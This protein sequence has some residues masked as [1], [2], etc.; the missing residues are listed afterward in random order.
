M[1]RIG[2]AI[3]QVP[4][5]VKVSI[6]DQEVSLESSKGKQSY[7]MPQG[8][9]ASLEEMNLSF[10]RNSE[11][12]KL[13]ALHGTTRANIANIAKGLS[14]GWSKSLEIIGVGYRVEAKGK[15]LNFILGYSHPILLNPPEGIEFKLDGNTKITVLGTDKQ[16]VG[17]VAAEIRA[18]RKPEPYKGKGIRYAGEQVR[19]KEVKKS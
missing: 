3:I 7:M 8:I 13:V 17:Q 18:Y 15:S 11:N 4:E 9:S 10:T 1:S 12:K 5:S 14:E 19:R 2:K 16:K 6:N